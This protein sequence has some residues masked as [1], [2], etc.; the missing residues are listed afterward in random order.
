MK[1]DTN[2]ASEYYILSSLYRLGYDAFITLGNKKSIDIVVKFGSTHSTI[3]VKGMKGTTSFP[4][5]N[6]DSTLKN[7]RHFLVFISFR[8]KISDINTVPEIYIV[9]SNKIEELTYI[10]PKGNRKVINLS[11]LRRKAK[12]YSNN[13]K[14]LEGR[15]LKKNYKAA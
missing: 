1:Y 8:N 15:M 4:I 7:K 14:L 6:F 13:W 12:Q 2:L 11:D 5:D 9:P 3:D 10:N